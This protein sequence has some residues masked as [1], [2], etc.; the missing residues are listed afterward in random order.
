MGDQAFEVI[1]HYATLT[2]DVPTSN[3][4]A[5]KT[6]GA[7]D[8]LASETIGKLPFTLTSFGGAVLGDDVYVYG[9]T[10]G[11]SH[12]YG[13]EL[14]NDALMRMKL[15]GGEWETVARGPRL[16]GLALVPHGGK[17]YRIG[18]FEA[19][20]SAGDDQD[21]WSVN[22]VAS[23]DPATG[24]WSELPPL[25]EPRSSFDAVVM[26]DHIYVMGGW[27]MAGDAKPVWHETAWKMDLTQN[28]PSWTAI[29]KAPFERRALALA[30]HDG[31][32][33]G[34]GGMTSGDE[35]SLET[36]IYDPATDSWSTGPELVG[37]S[38]MTGFGASAFAT[39]G[40]LYITTVTGSLQKL[41]KDGSAWT[42]VAEMPA[43]R[44]FHRMLPA[45]ES[46]FVLIGG[47]NMQSRI[48][49]VERIRVRYTAFAE[50]PKPPVGFPIPGGAGL[51]A[52]GQNAARIFGRVAGRSYANA[53]PRQPVATPGQP[54]ATPRER[55]RG[56]VRRNTSTRHSH[57][58]AECPRAPSRFNGCDGGFELNAGQIAEPSPRGDGGASSVRSFH[59][60]Q[61]H[62]AA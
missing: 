61:L 54:V 41:A 24:Q 55:R 57:Q 53:P 49:D 31:K 26:G 48:T 27:G 35:T 52:S 43:G 22:S 62:D 56:T 50:N 59:S 28:Q 33:Y 3:A 39:G 37:D 20:N 36:D 47:S 40:D 9:G 13:K 38:G 6:A 16:Q 32:L 44:F 46:T 18:G 8:G 17:L 23:F 30:A 10:M 21:L 12:Q 4:S 29:A 60:D 42:V 25:P 11:A 14:Q 1:R 45:S 51:V 34:I 19:R 2:L 15:T 58:P 7:S 5:S